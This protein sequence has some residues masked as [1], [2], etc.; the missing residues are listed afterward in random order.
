MDWLTEPLDNAFSVLNANQIVSTILSLVLMLYSGLAAPKLHPNVAKLF[1]HTWFKIIIITLIIYMVLKKDALTAILISV[2][3]VLSMQTVN[4]LTLE[5]T[6]KKQNNQAKTKAQEM[7]EVESVEEESAFEEKEGPIGEQGIPDSVK[8]GLGHGGTLVEEET[9]VENPVPVEAV[10]VNEATKVEEV[11]DS[12]IKDNEEKFSNHCD[13]DSEC[14]KH[15]PNYLKKEVRYLE[16][17]NGS[18]SGV[19]NKDQYTYVTNPKNTGLNNLVR[20]DAGTFISEPDGYQPMEANNFTEPCT[21]EYE[22]V[23]SL[24]KNL[25]DEKCVETFTDNTCT[26]S[27]G[28]Y[29]MVAKIANDESITREFQNPP[30][31][32]NQIYDRLN[33]G[34]TSCGSKDP[35]PTSTAEETEQFTV[36]PSSDFKL[37]DKKYDI[38]EYKTFSR[39]MATNNKGS[40]ITSDPIANNVGNTACGVR[41]SGFAAAYGS[42]D[43]ESVGTGTDISK[44]PNNPYNKKSSWEYTKDLIRTNYSE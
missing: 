31:S 2:G 8:K 3:F 22:Q 40:V 7:K 27:F 13:E 15:N 41:P 4:R 12:E 16:K 30:K 19:G 28:P 1:T 34:S 17:F 43:I 35:K 39:D 38:Q 29:K 33:S 44:D 23:R 18:C 20:N 14:A 25:K 36:T 32:S 10:A 11:S 37:L 21:A 6:L 5:S 24:C 42:D 26:K 9:P